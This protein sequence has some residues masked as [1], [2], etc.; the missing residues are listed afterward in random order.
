MG[1]KLIAL[2]VVVVVFVILAAAGYM[3]SSALETEEITFS[4]ENPGGSGRGSG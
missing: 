3:A 1:K 4:T 2:V